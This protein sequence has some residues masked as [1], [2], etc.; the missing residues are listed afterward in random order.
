MVSALLAGAFWDRFLASQRDAA[1]PE[2]EPMPVP[3]LGRLAAVAVALAFIVVAGR[4]EWTLM[5]ALIML[6]GTRHP[7]TADDRAELG[8]FRTLVGWFSLAIPVFCLTPF[9]FIPR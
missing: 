4:Y 7:P 6:L 2:E 1:S 5:L 9:P 8:R 3:G